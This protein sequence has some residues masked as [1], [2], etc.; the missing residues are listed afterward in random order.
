[1]RK[2]NTFN[3]VLIQIIYAV[4]VFIIGTV[5]FFGV[6]FLY[7]DKNLLGEKKNDSQNDTDL[8]E[9]NEVS[10]DWEKQ[11]PFDE[12]DDALT[13]NVYI[14][15]EYPERIGKYE[16]KIKKMKGKI[17]QYLEELL[18]KAELI[19]MKAGWENA[20]GWVDDDAVVQ[21]EN[22]FL[23]YIEPELEKAEVEKIAEDV[24]DL[25][26]FCESNGVSFLYINVGSK[27]FPLEKGIPWGVADYSNE[28]ADRFL[29]I[30]EDNDVEYMDMRKMMIDE[31]FNWE[32]CYYK[33]DHH[34]TTEMGLWAAEK[35]AE[36]MN[37]EGFAFEK[38]MFESDH[39]IKEIYPDLWI[40]GQ[41]RQIG[42]MDEWDDYDLLYPSFQTELEIDIPNWDYHTEGSYEDVL[43]D[44]GLL[45]SI[46]AYK[47]DDYYEKPDAYHTII[48]EN[49]PVTIE[50]THSMNNGRRI[51]ILRDSFGWYTTSFLATGVSEMATIHRDRFD[52]SIR[53][54]ISEYQPDAVLVMYGEF[55][56]CNHANTDSGLDMF[57]F[58]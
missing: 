57:D 6:V 7:L 37:T 46:R 45:E 26:A 23:T 16:N 34:W 18:P 4:A 21:M 5:F 50:K 27:V 40:G 56:I 2:K 8:I 28:N 35:I 12:T 48:I 54:F 32:N 10:I 19:K 58:R 47:R 43:L 3:A 44:K 15:C 24:V 17:E 51:L 41:G 30:L 38:E 14:S 13:E 11:Y 31:G 36:R 42:K 1:M 25:S 29:E 22:G 33:T 20:L 9:R 39:Y 49:Q 55:T 52:G 53:Q